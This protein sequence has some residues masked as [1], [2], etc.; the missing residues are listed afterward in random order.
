MMSRPEETSAT[1]S[2][3]AQT[4]GLHGD[5]PSRRRNHDQIRWSL[6]RLSLTALGSRIAQTTTTLEECSRSTQDCCTVHTSRGQ[7]PPVDRSSPNLPRTFFR[8]GTTNRGSS[9]RMGPCV[10]S[11]IN[12]LLAYLNSSFRSSSCSTAMLRRCNNTRTPHRRRRTLSL[13]RINACGRRFLYTCSPVRFDST[14]TSS[15]LTCV[16]SYLVETPPQLEYLALQ[17]NP[18][19]TAEHYQQIVRLQPSPPSTATIAMQQQSNHRE[20]CETH[21][22]TLS[23]SSCR[24]AHAPA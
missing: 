1:I 9:R 8:V 20:R 7:G 12:C 4:F 24:V 6:Q 10:A 11:P 2:S 16:F 5:S 17:N 18:R 21:R 19:N 15:T 3:H 23:T 22:G 14:L 13:E